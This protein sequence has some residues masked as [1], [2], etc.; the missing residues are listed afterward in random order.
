MCNTVPIASYVQRSGQCARTS[1]TAY[2]CRPRWSL[3]AASQMAFREPACEVARAPGSHAE[4]RCSPDRRAL[5]L[6]NASTPVQISQ[7]VL[8]LLL[9]DTA[10]TVRRNISIV[11]CT[12]LLTPPRPVLAAS[13]LD[14]VGHAL[15]ARP[16]E[17]IGVHLHGCDPLPSVT[18]RAG[19]REL[20]GPANE[21]ARAPRLRSPYSHY[22]WCAG[23]ETQITFTLEDAAEP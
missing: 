23:R 13:S 6:P 21:G 14:I 2:V 19:S 16:T 4:R 15:A 20:L 8:R 17:A 22:T 11:Q 10:R 1:S 3:G 9:V 5:F 12:T 18:A 7:S